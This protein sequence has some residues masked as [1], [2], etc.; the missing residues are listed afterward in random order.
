[1]SLA[2]SLPIE[3]LHEIFTV[4]AAVNTRFSILALV[5]RRWRE[6][7]LPSLWQ[8][9]RVDL[10]SSFVDFYHT[11][12]SFQSF[13]Y[14]CQH[15][16]SL[17]LHLEIPLSSKFIPPDVQGIE[18]HLQICRRVFR[19]PVY[20][21]DSHFIRWLYRKYDI[22]VGWTELRPDPNRIHRQL[23]F[24][25][26]LVSFASN[27]RIVSIEVPKT[28]Y[29]GIFPIFSLGLFDSEEQLV[30]AC[31]E[32]GR[33]IRRGVKRAG[34]DYRSFKSARQK[35]ITVKRVLS[36]V[37]DFI[38]NHKQLDIHLNLGLRLVYPLIL[39]PIPDGELT[40]RCQE[41]VL[42][43]S[44]ILEAASYII[45]LSVDL[46]PTSE[47]YDFCNML[48]KLRKPVQSLSMTVG[49]R[50]PAPDT[51][52]IITPSYYPDFWRCLDKTLTSLTLLLTNDSPVGL[53][54]T[55]PS[56]LRELKLGIHTHAAFRG[57]EAVELAFST[58]PNLELLFF[59]HRADD[60]E[61]EPGFQCPNPAVHLREFAI[62][63]DYPLPWSFWRFIGESCPSLKVL[64]FPTSEHSI[65]I[66][67][68]SHLA[69]E[70][71]SFINQ[72]HF[73]AGRLHDTLSYTLSTA[74]RHFGYRIRVE[75]DSPEFKE[76][77]SHKRSKLVGIAR[78]AWIDDIW[79]RI[80]PV[81]EYEQDL[82]KDWRD[83]DYDVAW[84]AEEF[85]GALS[86]ERGEYLP[87]FWSERVKEYWCVRVSLS[88]IKELS[89]DDDHEITAWDY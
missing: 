56:T 26:T 69:L 57:F 44:E 74:C 41:L 17:S 11:P 55:F 78:D 47:I 51:D 36:L 46:G 39:E 54:S 53:P 2:S 13:K 31:G 6:A 20:Y 23:K 22:R 27:L 4:A 88:T 35:W 65:P 76:M 85:E 33:K 30:F 52:H 79:V 16:R 25:C 19:K 82:E 59:W 68:V 70:T 71:V 86:I 37:K 58:L 10:A 84:V 62:Q 14:N 66:P 43:N 18:P 73:R 48:Q 87:N 8:Q 80:G 34:K 45:K 5:C 89:Q 72:E 32:K 64:R 49:T 40:R 28:N 77:I 61:Y 21:S 63:T 38:A 15:V 7:A 50:F 42:L 83:V 29:S 24:V 3:L 9:I 12:S 67:K 81:D 75:M 1:M 60:V